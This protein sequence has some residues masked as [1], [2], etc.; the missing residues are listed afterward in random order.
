MLIV[1]D[2]IA[3]VSGR[4]EVAFRL[5]EKFRFV[6]SFEEVEFVFGVAGPQHQV[7]D[8]KFMVFVDSFYCGREKIK[9]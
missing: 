8:E 2:V 9:N 6:G 1:V 7:V 3:F 4:E 5:G